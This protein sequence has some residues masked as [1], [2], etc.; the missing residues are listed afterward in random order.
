MVNAEPE[1]ELLDEIDKWRF[2]ALIILQL[3]IKRPVP[4]NEDYLTRKGFN[5]KKRP[6]ALTLKMLHNFV[7]VCNVEEE[8]EVDIDIEE[9]IDK[10]KKTLPP[11]KE[12]SDAILTA[13]N[14]LVKSHP[15]LSSVSKI[16][17][18]RRR[19]LK[20]RY[21]NKHF[22]ENWEK[23]IESIP[24]YPFL[25]GKNDWKWKISFDWLIANDTNYL[26]ILEGKYSNKQYDPFA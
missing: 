3:Q 5:L 11:V 19:S 22:R 8:V 17:P 13:W 23:V 15:I 18:D 24:K 4:L 20:A 2:I 16:S 10:G 6:I 12:F 9:E 26:K 21:S 7:E 14:E 25:L 1:F